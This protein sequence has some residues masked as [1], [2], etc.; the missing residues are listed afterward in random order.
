MNIIFTY[1]GITFEWNKEKAV[2]N[3]RKHN[4]SFEKACETFFDPFLLPLDSD[5]VEGEERDRLIGL[6][7]DWQLLLVVYLLKEDTIRIISARSTTSSERK[8]YET[9]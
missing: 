4:I 6:T 5:Y 8:Q 7:L 2:S 3:F 1:N 9:R